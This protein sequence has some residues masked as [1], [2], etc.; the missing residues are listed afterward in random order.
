MHA[1]GRPL[2][3]QL[4]LNLL[5]LFDTVFK[6]RNLT[7][8]GGLLGLSQPA[9]SHG[10][11]KLRA[12][13]GDAL[14]VRV[15]RGVLPT[16]FAEGLA[17]PIAQALTIVRGTIERPE[18]IARTAKRRFRIAMSDIGERY[19]LPRLAGWLATEAPGVVIESVTPPHAELQAGLASGDIDLA[20]G[21]TP[22][23]GKQFYERKLFTETFV[24]IARETHPDVDAALTVPQLR[25]LQHVLASPL[26]TRHAAAIDKVL[27]SARVRADVRLRV[28][29][30]LAVGPIVA[31]TDLVSVVPGNLA[32]LLS[33]H[34]SLQILK[35][36]VRF[37]GF[38]VS[39]YWHERVHREPGLEWIRASLS[40]LFAT[41]APRR[42]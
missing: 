10:L 1:D 23:L 16:P 36:P 25:R 27:T 13:Y 41:T 18:F 7:T 22:D 42:P 9:V 37:P 29:N 21:F 26:G 11:A 3:R 33:Q 31:A 15:Q 12:M 39:M 35:P 4:D 34:L 32:Q 24:Y 20:V 28:R 2:T 40:Q 38:Q 6:T 14:F 30:F 19:F 5:E 8:C 17:A